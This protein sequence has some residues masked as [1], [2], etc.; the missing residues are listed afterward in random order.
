MMS[1][2]EVLPIYELQCTVN[3]VALDHLKV[4]KIN[5]RCADKVCLY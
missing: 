4:T 2:S 3:C 1:L 5:S